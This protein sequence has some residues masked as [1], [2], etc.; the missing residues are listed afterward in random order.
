MTLKSDFEPAM[1][2]LNRA[3]AVR[4]ECE[5]AIIHTPA[6]ESKANGAV[7]RAIRIWKGQTT[8]MRLHLEDRIK[9]TIDLK[10]PSLS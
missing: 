4:R 3:L 9:S 2:A 10:H 1:Q 6:R 8:A 7:E 5:T